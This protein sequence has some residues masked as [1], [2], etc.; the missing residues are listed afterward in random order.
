PDLARAQGLHVEYTV[1][2]QRRGLDVDPATV[3]P[4]LVTQGKRPV[5]GC[6]VFNELRFDFVG[7][8]SV[9]GNLVCEDLLTL[10]AGGGFAVDP[11]FPEALAA[12]ASA[13]E[14]YPIDLLRD[15]QHDWSKV[16]TITV[17]YRVDG[18]ERQLDVD[19]S[20]VMPA[21][22]YTFRTEFQYPA[23]P[24]TNAVV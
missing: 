11:R 12:R 9:V 15:N 13:A 18:E 24:E 7:G 22:R 16:A 5:P 3:L 19:P 14:G 23:G 1:K 21:F 2:G 6:V 4:A 17:R 20:A 8:R 10:R